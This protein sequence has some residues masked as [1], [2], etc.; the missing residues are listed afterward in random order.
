MKRVA[1]TG[2]SGHIGA[3]LVIELISRGYQVVVL[4]RAT[5]LALE[6]LDVTRVNADISDLQSL[7]RA[8]KGVDQVYHLAAFISMQSCDSAKLNAINVGG[9]ANVIAACQSEGVSTLVHFSTIHAL[10]QEPMDQEVNEENPLIDGRLIDGQTGRGGDYEKS[11]AR[12]EVLVREIS[13]GTLQTRII[14]PTGVL[15]PNDFNLSLLGKAILEMAQGRLPAL[16]RGGYD[17]VDVRD[18]AWGSVEVVEKGGDGDRFILSGHYRSMS[19]VAAEIATQ[20]GIAAPRICCPLWLA[21]WFAPVMGAWA[22]WRGETSLYTRDS[23]AALSANKVM[24]HSLATA[25]LGYEPRS[26]E[27]S[28]KDTLQF[29]AETNHLKTPK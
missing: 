24:S 23:L 7:C 15:G 2:A 11:K 26:F 4:I 14:Y 3:N 6:G 19:E 13:P 9:T 1:V 12:A 28:I 18:V 17:W 21:A 29:Y 10:E 22:R 8:F 25:K 27:E 20:T 16:V 5:S